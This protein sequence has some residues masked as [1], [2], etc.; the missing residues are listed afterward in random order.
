MD[1]EL[2]EKD[3]D[4]DVPANFPLP[5]LPMQAGNLIGPSEAISL[6]EYAKVALRP[7]WDRT[8]TR[9]ALTVF[10][11]VLLVSINVYQ[12]S[13]GHY[14]GAVIIGFGISLTWTFNIRSVAFGGWKE[15]LVY[16]GSAAVGTLT[17]MILPQLF[18]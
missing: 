2:Q 15:R 13:H 9:L 1:H 16:S 3:G 4:Y 5:E 10:V 6:R 11:Q 14:L 8:M 18:Y 7:K 12:I 17:G